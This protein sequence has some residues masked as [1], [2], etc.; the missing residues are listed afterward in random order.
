MN[1]VSFDENNRVWIGSRNNGIFVLDYNGTLGNKSDDNWF[2][3]DNNELRSNT[4]NSFELGLDGT[5]WIG[6]PDGINYYSLNSVGSLISPVS[7]E[8]HCFAVDGFDNLWVGTDKGIGIF[9]FYDYK[10]EIY[11]SENSPLIDNN[12]NSIEINRKNG[13]VF[14]GTNS[15]LSNIT[16]PFKTPDIKYSNVIIYPNPFILSKHNRLII[17][18]LT[19][20]SSVSVFSESGR[21]IRKLAYE[22]SFVSGVEGYWDGKNESGDK[23]STGIYI[24]AVFDAAGNTKSF[25]VAVIR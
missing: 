1:T 11:N 23:V 6:T 21:L 5:V 9:N 24:I 18:N 8:I 17:K 20:F 4:I 3:F 10:W 25:K 19:G 13:D 2:Y 16:T 22:S 14:I 7:S 15:G 12:I